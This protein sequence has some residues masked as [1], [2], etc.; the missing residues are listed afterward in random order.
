MATPEREYSPSPNG[1]RPD[2][3]EPFASLMRRMLAEPHYPS[4]QAA[5]FGQPYAP[6]PL[7]RLT[8]ACLASIVALRTLPGHAVRLAWTVWRAV[9]VLGH[10]TVRRLGH[11]QREP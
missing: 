5:A 6:S 9:A 3:T 11:E 1:S 4:R 8:L 2:D 10:A 7:A